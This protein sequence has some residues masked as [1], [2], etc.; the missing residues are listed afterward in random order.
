MPRRLVLAS[1]SIYRRALLDKLGLA[2]TCVSPN[3]DE[4]ARPGE[5]ADALVRR[6]ALDK[7]RAV[8]R[9]EPDALIIGSDQVATL[10][11]QILGKPLTHA[12]AAQQLHAASGR[13]VRFI[14]GLCL[15]DSASGEYQ[16]VAEP[17]DVQFRSLTEQQIDNYIRREQPLQCAGSFK[18]E[19]LGIVL[20][21]RLIGDDPNS[22]IGLP[23]IR[24]TRMLEQA[25]VDV[26][27]AD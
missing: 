13:Q 21:E 24:L 2:Y 26:L 17:F 6:L 3:I 11:G 1:G 7:A 27:G 10:D 19:G 15:F 9:T 5:D 23:L 25:G 12:R 16:V 8:A 18:S 20:F 4:T 22:L 14:T